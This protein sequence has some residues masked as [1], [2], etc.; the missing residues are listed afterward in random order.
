MK[1]MR[2]PGG[3][4]SAACCRRRTGAAPW[5]GAL[6]G[7][8]GG[9]HWRGAL[10]PDAPQWR[11]GGTADSAEDKSKFLCAGEPRLSPP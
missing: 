9:A 7:R 6:E 8:T 10:R 5:R 3:R 11:A 1:A 2:A 4:S